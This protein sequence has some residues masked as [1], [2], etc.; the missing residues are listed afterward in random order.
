M[1][2]SKTIAVTEGV[3]ERLREVMKRE[4]AK[5]MNEAVLK[6]MEKAANVPSS[7]FGVHKKL[8]LRYTQEEHD[9]ITKDTH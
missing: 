4:R 2:K 9:E 1:A 3:W 8:N 6:L 7:R 5:S